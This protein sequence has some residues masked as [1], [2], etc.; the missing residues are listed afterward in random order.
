MLSLTL[1]HGTQLGVLFSPA[2]LQSA[3]FQTLAGFVAINTVMYV[4]LAVTKI[5][6]KVYLSD[7]HGSRLRRS[8][9]R[10]IYPDRPD[11][12]HAHSRLDGLHASSD[13]DWAMGGR[14]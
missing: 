13:D 12:R 10:S 4:A 7:W 5:L 3:W 8:E 2:L 6:P 9:T 1:T 14:P 11:P